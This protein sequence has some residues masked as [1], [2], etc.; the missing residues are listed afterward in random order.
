[1]SLV[2]GFE[3]VLAA[4]EA[5]QQPPRSGRS[6]G[7]RRALRKAGVAVALDA[8]RLE[9]ERLERL[10][11]DAGRVGRAMMLAPSIEACEALLRGERVPLDRL[12]PEWLARFGRRAP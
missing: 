3:T 10:W 11:P 4:I 9:R 12:D 8:V 6:E 5:G 1:M 2:A 7:S